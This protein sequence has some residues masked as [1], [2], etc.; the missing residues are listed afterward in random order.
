[1]Q[2]WNFIK[3]YLFDP[4]I[5]FYIFSIFTII[6]LYFLYQ[7][8][9]FNADFLNFGPCEHTKFLSMKINSWNRVY[10][11]WII[12]FT[13]AFFTHYY[14]SVNY[15]FVFSK[16]WN[17]AYKK[18]INFSKKTASF[19][20]FFDPIL[21]YITMIL[22]LFVNLTM[23]LQ[24]ILPGF[25]GTIMAKIPYAYHKIEEKKTQFC[26]SKKSKSKIKTV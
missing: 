21:N 6:Y 23:Q 22:N 1:M 12:G 20:M 18:K 13:T 10:M 19:L 26:I 24:F 8:N 25:L 17:P 3:N 14:R 2:Y 16:I 5:T 7:N 11:L 4:K 15:D 9:A